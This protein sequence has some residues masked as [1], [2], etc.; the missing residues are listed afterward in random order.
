[1]RAPFKTI[2]SDY[3]NKTLNIALDMNADWRNTSHIQEAV[4][5]F[6]YCSLDDE[7]RADKISMVSTELV[8]NAI[9]YGEARPR[10][11]EAVKFS[12]KADVDKIVVEVRNRV[13]TGE[14]GEHVRRLDETIQ[15]IRGFENPFEAY[16]KRLYLAARSTEE[17]SCLGMAR[18]AY[19]AEALLDF[20]ENENEQ[21]TVQA[22]IP[23]AS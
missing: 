18:M 1:M 11:S 15:W 9:K 14:Y 20:A 5:N 19:E 12:L 17:E 22:V 8:E 10:D 13:K 21:I 23:L 7:A 16:M 2:K 4:W 3:V 6:I